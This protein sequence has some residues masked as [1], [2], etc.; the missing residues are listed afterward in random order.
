MAK[1]FNSEWTNIAWLL[2][3]VP[4]GALFGALDILAIHAGWWVDSSGMTSG[5]ATLLG[6]IVG[7][8]I[9]FGLQEL[10]FHRKDN[11]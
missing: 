8:A 4:L 3:G 10:Y 5:G 1:L 9:F 11:A 7:A 2:L 6:L